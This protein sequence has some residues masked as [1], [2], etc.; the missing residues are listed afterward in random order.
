MEP[1]PLVI[2]EEIALEGLDGITP[3]SNILFNNVILKLITQ[4]FSILVQALG[5]S[6]LSTSIW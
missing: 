3:Q 5:T 6:Q 1:I 4:F 2:E